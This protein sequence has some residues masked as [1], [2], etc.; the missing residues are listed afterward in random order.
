MGLNGVIYS[1]LKLKNFKFVSGGDLN[2]RL[3]Y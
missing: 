3:S 2:S 1:F